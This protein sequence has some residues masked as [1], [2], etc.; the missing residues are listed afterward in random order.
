MDEIKIDKGIPLP[1]ES[2]GRKRKYP[3]AD[4]L[5]GDSFFTRIKSR[6]GFHTN[7]KR[8]GI[9]ITTRKEAEGF[10]VWRTE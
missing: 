3:W 1:G 10:R 8:A 6:K 9:K 2:R 5:I 4:M 7:A